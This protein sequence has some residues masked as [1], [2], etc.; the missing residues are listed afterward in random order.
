MMATQA[1][2]ATGTQFGGG[3]SKKPTRQALQLKDPEAFKHYSTTA[4]KLTSSFEASAPCLDWREGPAR[5]AWRG[6]EEN[7]AEPSRGAMARKP[8]ATA[9]S[10]SMS[11]G[12]S[13]VLGFWS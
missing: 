1:T 11:L 3:V 4:H 8:R 9:S 6:Q 10:G 13:E 2:N 7:A 5:E 12:F